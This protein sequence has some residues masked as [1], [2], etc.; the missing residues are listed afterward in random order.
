[1]AQSGL[2]VELVIQTTSGVLEG[3]FDPREAV[4]ILA[5]QTPLARASARRLARDNPEKASAYAGILR[6]IG[7]EVRTR[8]D[9]A[10]QPGALRAVMQ[11]L[12]ALLDALDS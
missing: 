11:D 9:Q 8:A 5:T 12:A 10:A 3:R 7:R 6:A 4:T 2:P 1:M